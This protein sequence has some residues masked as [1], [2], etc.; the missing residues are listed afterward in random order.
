LWLDSSADYNQAQDMGTNKVQEHDEHDLY[1]NTN[2][3]SAADGYGDNYLYEGG[4]D[5]LPFHPP[6]SSFNPQGRHMLLNPAQQP[7]S[8]SHSRSHSHSHSHS[9]FPSVA[10]STHHLATQQPQSPALEGTLDLPNQNPV[11]HSLH[12]PSHANYQC[13][14]HSPSWQAL[15]Q[16]PPTSCQ[17]P[18]QPPLS[19]E[20]SVQPQLPPSCQGSVQPLLPPSRQS[21]VTPPP[22]TYNTMDQYEPEDQASISEQG[23]VS[24]EELWPGISKK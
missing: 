7:T 13:S 15:L 19:H 10:L 11:H 17:G 12:A 5:D 24:E 2:G 3:F 14:I 1:N 9:R 8:C 23:H 20:D 6:S 4:A 21:S 16:P 18:V 22:H